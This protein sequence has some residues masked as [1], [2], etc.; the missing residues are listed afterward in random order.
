MS[1]FV[2][3]W[4]HISGYN[5]SVALFHLQRSGALLADFTRLECHA[6][7][8]RDADQN[9]QPDDTPCP[10]FLTEA[11]QGMKAPHDNGRAGNGEDEHKNVHP[12]LRFKDGLIN[13]EDD[14]D[15][16]RDE[17]ENGRCTESGSR[18]DGIESV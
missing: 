12:L 13:L 7:S 5:F 11:A 15:D 1:P 8:Q 16:G 3:I 14:T 18:H 9:L 6:E 10:S 4:F 17:N 2:K